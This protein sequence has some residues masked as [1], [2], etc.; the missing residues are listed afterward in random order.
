[1]T[2]PVL[3]VLGLS[4]TG[5]YVVR[6]GAG[7]GA[8]VYGF[9]DR[10]ECGADSRHLQNRG[11]ST[12]VANCNLAAVLNELAATYEKVAVIPTT[13]RHVEFICKERDKLDSG[14]VFFDGYAN[15]AA[16]LALD[17]AHLYRL[18]ASLGM[19]V[20]RTK[21]LGVNA[22]EGEPMGFP[23]LLKPR[24]IHRQRGW[25]RGKKVLVVKNATE[26]RVAC[27]HPEFHPDEWTAQELIYGPESNIYVAAVWRS[28]SGE[29]DVF[30]GRKL[31][32]YP[33]NFGSA[34]MVVDEENR[35]V[36]KLAMDLLDKIQFQGIAGVEF[37]W[38]E[39]KRGYSLIEINPRPSLWFGA[40]TAAGKHLIGKQLSDWF[41]G[42]SV[43]P[44]ARSNFMWRYRAKDLLS[45]IGH[46]RADSDFPAPDLSTA[47]GRD[48]VWAV[49]QKDDWRP[50]VREMLVYVQ[51]GFQRLFS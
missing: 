48:T 28:R 5:L 51:K 15:G 47:K 46:R 1:M 22:G 27:G 2:V 43:E 6:E 19:Q 37:K 16:Q 3:V 41:P 4:P 33:V 49:F 40:T 12:V 29:F 42:I 18:A 17:K 10:M 36:A 14:L 11:R 39:S 13:D 9:S 26:L 7:H 44:A 38:D 30:T 25:L 21:A 35:H 31:R 32:Q 45:A 34:T 24:S 50:M 8:R 20:P 23:F